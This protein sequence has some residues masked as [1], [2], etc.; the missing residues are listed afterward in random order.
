M[1]LTQAVRPECTVRFR[2]EP[3]S[4]AFWGNR[5]T[6]HLAPADTAHLDFPRTMHRV[7]LA[8]DVPVGMDGKASEVIVGS[9]PGR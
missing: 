9:E 4:V 6:I 8:G 1:L 7:M 3:G 5:A 2:W